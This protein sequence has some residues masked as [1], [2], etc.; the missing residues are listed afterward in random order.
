MDNN[1]MSLWKL[2]VPA[3]ALATGLALTVLPGCSSNTTASLQNSDQT[4]SEQ[5]NEYSSPAAMEASSAA[6]STA[7]STESAQAMSATASTAPAAGASMS[8]SANVG[9]GQ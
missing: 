8:V 6:M 7:G 9:A 2:G 3:V 5:P 4:A 1:T